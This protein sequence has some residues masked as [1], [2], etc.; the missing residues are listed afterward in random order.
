M[1]RALSTTALSGLLL[2]TVS[3]CSPSDQ[4]ADSVLAAYEPPD[5]LVL[6]ATPERTALP[7]VPLVS[8]HDEPVDSQALF[9]DH[10]TLFYVGYSFC[11][12]IC[13]AE[14]SVLAQVLPELEQNHP[15]IDWQVVFLSVDPVRDT[16]ARLAQY[17]NFFSPDI[18]AVTGERDAIDALTQPVR[19]GYRIEEHE[20]GD[21]SYIIDH[22]INFRLISPEGEMWA[23]LPP[24]HYS[25][26]M[27][28]ALDDFIS[29]VIKP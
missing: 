7:D 28:P 10:W 2:L 8:M 15:E 9:A 17:T 24:P 16:P 19:A 23:I 12:D 21:N 1:L 18:L 4:Q 6:R 20:P 14:L 26:E 3:G 11:P 5:H 13:P 22:D 27:L 25:A 29:E